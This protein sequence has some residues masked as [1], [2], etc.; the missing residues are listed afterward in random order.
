MGEN[1]IQ[2]IGPNGS[3]VVLTTR[4]VGNEA[5][6]SFRVGCFLYHILRVGFVDCRFPIKKG[7]P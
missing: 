5:E 2:G 4:E 6:W 3:P 1:K 7:R